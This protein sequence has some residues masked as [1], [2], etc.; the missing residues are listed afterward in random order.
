MRRTSI[1]T[2]LAWLFDVDVDRKKRID[3]AIDYFGGELINAARDPCG[4]SLLDTTGADRPR[5]GRR[6]RSNSPAR[7]RR[8]D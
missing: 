8:L 5:G 6:P 1:E 7:C 2:A 3:E 4:E